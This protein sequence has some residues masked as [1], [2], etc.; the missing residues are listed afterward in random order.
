M[1]QSSAADVREVLLDTDDL[2]ELTKLCKQIL[3]AVDTSPLHFLQDGLR[4]RDINPR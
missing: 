3:E 1:F 2:E 4:D